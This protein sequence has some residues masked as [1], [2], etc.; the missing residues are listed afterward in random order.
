MAS[1][2]QR[3]VSFLLLR[4]RECHQRVRGVRNLRRGGLSVLK[5][6]WESLLVVSHWSPSPHL[7][8]L[9]TAMLGR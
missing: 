4:G 7:Y 9:S 5:V 1:V 8:I 6:C 3:L 2:L